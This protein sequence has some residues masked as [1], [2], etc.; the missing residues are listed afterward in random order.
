MTNEQAAGGLNGKTPWE[1][2][3]A[4][5]GVY[6]ITHSIRRRSLTDDM[7][8][9]FIPKDIDSDEFAAWL[10]SQYRLA[11]SKGIEIG[12]E[13]SRPQPV[14]TVSG[15]RPAIDYAELRKNSDTAVLQMQAARRLNPDS[16]NKPCDAAKGT[17]I[18]G[19][20]SRPKARQ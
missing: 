12:M 14:E 20:A 8:P 10:T 19:S 15:Q 1:F 11:M 6:E 3:C 5:Y 17:Y 16:L 4:W 9:S 18:L 13:A 7:D 2:A